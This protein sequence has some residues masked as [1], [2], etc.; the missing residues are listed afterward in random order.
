MAPSSFQ[1]LEIF[2][3]LDDLWR[4]LILLYSDMINKPTT[5]SKPA[6]AQIWEMVTVPWIEYDEMIRARG[7][8]SL[9]FIA[10]NSR[11]ARRREEWACIVHLIAQIT[12]DLQ[13]S[14]FND[15]HL[16]PRTV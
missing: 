3:L 15:F 7:A 2:K 5:T 1:D 8:E 13:Y 11:L 6:D 14:R 9:I 12:S 16:L 4:G 10:Y